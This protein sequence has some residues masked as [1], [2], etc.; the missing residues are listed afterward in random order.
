VRN[1]LELAQARPRA[2][3]VA[4]GEPVWGL[5]RNS[6]RLEETEVF[7]MW[8]DPAVSGEPLEAE[9]VFDRRGYCYDVLR[10]VLLGTSARIRVRLA[11]GA[12][13]FARMPYDVE[14]ISIRAREQ[15]DDIAYEAVVETDTGLAGTHVVSQELVYQHGDG[16]S[17]PVPG[18]SRVIIAE[19]GVVKGRVRFALNEPGGEYRLVLRDATTGVEG[20][21]TITRGEGELAKRFPLEPARDD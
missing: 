2:E 18:G 1:A 5:E 19:R 11:P 13:V 17:R 8:L 9:L 12:N 15:G 6:W 20:S 16:R 7:T 4:R 3:V 10:G 21:I 14:S